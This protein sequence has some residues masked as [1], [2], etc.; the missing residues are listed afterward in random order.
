MVTITWPAAKRG[1]I[2]RS[3]TIE[4]EVR[5]FYPLI[6]WWGF[7]LALALSLWA[8]SL[9]S[10]DRQA[11]AIMRQYFIWRTA[12]HLSGF[13]RLTGTHFIVLYPPGYHKDARLVEQVAEAA[14]PIETRDLSVYP[15]GRIL[16]VVWPSE[17]A[18]NHA[19]SVP[20]QDN[21]IG[22][23]YQGVIDVLAPSSWLGASPAA[24]QQYRRQGPVAHELGHELLNFKADGNY[25][26]WFN[27]GVAQYEDWRVTGYQ[28]LTRNNY[29]SGPLYPPG[30]LTRHFYTLPHQSR[31][32]R[33]SLALVQYLV[34]SHGLATFDRFLARLGD[35]QS[36]DQALQRTYRLSDTQALFQAWHLRY[37]QHPLPSFNP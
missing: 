8:V 17:K 7:V 2:M 9:P 28:W 13:D 12:R 35:N 22:F 4:P 25:P 18:M 5:R 36:F 31:A 26:D 10:L 32:Y 20:A 3:E 23:D 19:V 21:D 27:E 15:S 6:A 14:W 16:I 24:S 1:N 34:A 29:L 30:E 11:Y 37:R 33:E